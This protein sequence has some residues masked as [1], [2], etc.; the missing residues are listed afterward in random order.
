MSKLHTSSAFLS[1]ASSSS[2]AGFL[3]PPSLTSSPVGAHRPALKEPRSPTALNS[4]QASRE[5][6]SGQ[7]KRRR[8][9]RSRIGAGG[10]EK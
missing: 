3:I 8:R 7:G 4:L 9:R 6:S 2:S 10:R 5:V 1:R